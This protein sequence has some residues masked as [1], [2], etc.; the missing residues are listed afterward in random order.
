MSHL[1]MKLIETR[2]G[3][4]AQVN[5]VPLAAMLEQLQEERRQEAEARQADTPRR[6]TAEGRKKN[7]EGSK[8][9]RRE[10][11]NVPVLK[12]PDN[13]EGFQ[14]LLARAL[15][16]DGGSE[17]EA[18]VAQR[19]A[20]S[21]WERLHWWKRRT[22][23]EGQRLERL[24]QAGAAAPLDSEDHPRQRTYYI[25]TV[26]NLDDLFVIRLNHLTAQVRDDLRWWIGQRPMIRAR[27]VSTPSAKP[28]AG[29][30]SDRPIAGSTHP[31]AVA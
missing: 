29:A 28:P 30:T 31:S 4:E 16:L 13:L 15:N 12:L 1:L 11:S 3:A 8:G 14:R 22:D 9:Q 19:L 23:A 25:N 10:P 24:L 2:Y 20:E 18:G 7:P 5:G 27:R 26:L 6:G 21:I 17:A